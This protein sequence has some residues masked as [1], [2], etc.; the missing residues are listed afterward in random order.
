MKE[1]IIPSSPGK[2]FTWI[3]ISQ[4]EEKELLQIADEFKLHPYTVRD[5]MERGHLPKIETID[6]VTFIITRLY[7][8]KDGKTDSVQDITSKVA[9]FYSDHFVIT[10]HRVG[11]PFP[12]EVK[13]MFQSKK[14]VTP[15]KIVTR[16]LWQVI[17][18]YEKPSDELLQ[19]VDGYES[20]IFLKEHIANLQQS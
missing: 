6:N 2:P 12:E 15:L 18:T 14:D 4:P 20:R 3:D 13:R 16:L 11:W 5:S 9:I 1:V 19:E 17:H 7:N 10:I 8:P